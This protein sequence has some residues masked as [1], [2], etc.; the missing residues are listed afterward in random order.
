MVN[1]AFRVSPVAGKMKSRSKALVKSEPDTNPYT[2][3]LILV[4]LL[5]SS[6]PQVMKLRAMVRSVLLGQKIQPLA[7]EAARTDAVSKK[8]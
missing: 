8:K 4:L 3:F 5:L 7:G 1:T 2:L 6:S